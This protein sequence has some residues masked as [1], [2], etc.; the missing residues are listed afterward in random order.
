MPSRWQGSQ[1]LEFAQ[2][3]QQ[4]FGSLG[5]LDAF[6][7]D[8][9]GAIP[10]AASS[11]IHDGPGEKPLHPL[12]HRSLEDRSDQGWIAP[13]LFKQPDQGRGIF[14]SVG[15]VRLQS[16][17]KAPG[18]AS[19]PLGQVPG[20]HGATPAFPGIG[21]RRQRSQHT[22]PQH[23]QSEHVP[24]EIRCASLQSFG[25]K[26]FPGPF[27]GRNR[28]IR[29]GRQ[30]EIDHGHFAVGPCDEIGGGEISVHHA[31]TVEAGHREC[32]LQN[33]GPAIRHRKIGGEFVQ[34]Q[35][36]DPGQADP[37]MPSR[38][39][40]SND[41]RDGPPCQP[42]KKFGLP[43]QP[44]PPRRRRD[45]EHHPPP[46]V[47]LPAED[48]LAFASGSQGNRGGETPRKRVQRVVPH[49]SESRMAAMRSRS[50]VLVESRFKPNCQ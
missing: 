1:S 23:P 20:A 5:P 17:R 45:L 21:I 48:G 44:L 3:G 43:P 26:D 38:Q 35:S 14:G 29:T 33:Q 39:I 6:P 46:G 11:C 47:R 12:I 37:R 36:V 30:P 27:H 28:A 50:H 32:G 16:Q 40:L 18:P 41:R 31:G 4:S 34:R 19:S 13:I 8:F 7:L 15:G 9:P 25:R 2:L 10:V 49:P 22:Q 42:G 24:A